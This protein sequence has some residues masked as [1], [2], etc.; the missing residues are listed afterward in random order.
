MVIRVIRVIRVMRVI[1]V[2]RV[3]GLLGSLEYD[4]AGKEVQAL[5]KLAP[6][7]NSS[8]GGSSR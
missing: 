8:S 6:S 7:S 4:F 5:K 3:L 1:R 2:I